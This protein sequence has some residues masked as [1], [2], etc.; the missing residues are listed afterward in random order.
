MNG[1]KLQMFYLPTSLTVVLK[2]AAHTPSAGFW[3]LVP[4]RRK[5]DFIL[6]EMVLI[7]FELSGVYLKDLCKHSLL[8]LLGLKSS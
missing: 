5:T 8:F 7:S 2:I 1:R 4:R 3:S 6:K